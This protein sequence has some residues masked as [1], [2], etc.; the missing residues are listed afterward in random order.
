M[1][2][3]IFLIVFP[4]AAWKAWKNIQMARASTS[5]PTTAGNVVA[6]EC[7]KVMFRKQ[8]RVTYSYAVNGTAYSSQRISFAGGYR[9]KETDAI[10]A[11]YPVG[12]EISVSY[13]PD[14]P[15]ESTLE[16]GANKQVTA[17][18]RML[19]IFFVVIVLLNILTY[20]LRGL[21]TENRRPG[22][23]YG[24]AVLHLPKAC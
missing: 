10:L 21:N 4:F 1:L 23:T 11:R 7:V 3:L 24:L 9:P 6:S 14:K 17:Q 16:T 19:L 15:A 13:A 12:S 5:W 20:Y 8:P 22:R 2:S 18:L